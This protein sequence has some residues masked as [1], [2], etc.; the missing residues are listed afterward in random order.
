MPDIALSPRSLWQALPPAVRY[1]LLVNGSGQS[2]LL[3]IAHAFAD[4]VN[5]GYPS[6]GGV[7]ERV[8]C[9]MVVHA[10]ELDPFAQTAAARV[11][12]LHEQMPF[13]T[14][15]VAAFCAACRN[16]R[17]DFLGEGGSVA[18][19][20]DAGDTDGARAALARLAA[21][22]PDSLFW[23]RFAAHLGFFWNEPDWF[24]PWLAIPSLP[25]FAAARFRADL[26]FAREEWEE[27]LALYR[28]SFAASE[29][30]ETLVR[31]GECA[32]RA[33]KRDL[34]AA[35]WRTALSRR[36]WQVNLVHRLY[37]LEQGRD[38]PGTLPSGRGEIFLYS[39]NNARELEKTLAALA[40]SETGD[41]AVTVSSGT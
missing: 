4:A 36:P 15:P 19:M 20:L 21:K 31:A 2:R 27:A 1:P 11:L 26:F 3:R 32:K 34:A 37:D 38:L 29:L 16:C 33:G 7:L 40:A 6:P 8:L 17:T 28:E 24:E 41:A 22:E 14:P 25:P 18:A 39:W 12:Q 35:I 13:L 30:A 10:W 23:F 9:D 5:A